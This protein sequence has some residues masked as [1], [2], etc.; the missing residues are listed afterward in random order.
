MTDNDVGEN[1]TEDDLLIMN[2]TGRSIGS[3]P[4]RFNLINNSFGS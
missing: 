1:L 4:L 2:K 3:K